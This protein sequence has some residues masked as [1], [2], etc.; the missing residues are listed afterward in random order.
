MRNDQADQLK[1]KTEEMNN[2]WESY[3]RELTSSKDQKIE[4]I[5][6]EMS[7]LNASLTSKTNENSNLN[8]IIKSEKEI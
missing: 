3:M 1:Q 8:D 7:R 4:Q 6:A 2:K 5:T